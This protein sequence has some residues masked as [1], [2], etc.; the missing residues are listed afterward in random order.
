MTSWIYYD[1]K[2][3]SPKMQ[4][5]AQYELLWEKAVYVSLDP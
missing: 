4:L 1:V 5:E 2:K 3:K